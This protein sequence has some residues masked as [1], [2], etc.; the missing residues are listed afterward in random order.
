MPPDDDEFEGVEVSSPLGQVRVGRGGVHVGLGE[1]DDGVEEKRVRR[2]VRR[3]L[4]FYRNL[5][6]FVVIVGALALIDF[7]T[8]GGWWVQ[9]V[10]AI[11]GG[12]LGLQ[13]LS[14]FIAPLLWGREA[15]ERLVQQEMERRRRVPPPDTSER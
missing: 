11:W 14:T 15:E 10:A 2:R 5:T 8:G 3:R 7:A 1:E 6:F 13:F 12:I 9:W 4:D